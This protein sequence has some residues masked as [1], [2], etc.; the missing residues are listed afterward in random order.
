MPSDRFITAFIGLLDPQ[1]HR[2][3]FQSGGQGPIL[4]FHAARGDRTHHKPTSFPLAAMP[5][6]KLRPSIEIGLE[7][8]DILALSPTASTNT[9]RRHRRGIR[10]GARARLLAAHHGKPAA[11][12]CALLF[13]AVQEFAGSAPQEDDMTVVLVKREAAP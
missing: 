10:R 12:I 8:G 13:A 11:E 4:H 7:P 1:T 9:T 5:I 6:T 2:L 3:R